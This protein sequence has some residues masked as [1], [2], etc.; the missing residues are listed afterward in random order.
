MQCNRLQT[1]LDA[2]DPHDATADTLNNKAMKH[3]HVFGH[4]EKYTTVLLC[5]FKK[6]QPNQS[7]KKNERPHKI[8]KA[9]CRGGWSLGMEVKGDG[10]CFQ[11]L[12]GKVDLQAKISHKAK[13]TSASLV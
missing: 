2:A 6:K 1:L 11:V 13:Q 12:S 7:L 10:K 8:L 4:A 3:M 5:N 9:A